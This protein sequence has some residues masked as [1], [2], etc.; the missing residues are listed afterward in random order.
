[1][2]SADVRALFLAHAYPRY[3][4]DPVG[5][6]V[7]NLAVALG[8]RGVEVVVSAPSAPGLAPFD[9]VN[10]VPVH[11][12]RYAPE[13]RETLAYTGTMGAQVKESLAGK[14]TMTS[15]LAAATRAAH[16]LLRASRFD[17][18]H[19]HWWFPAG[20]VAAGLRSADRVPFVTTLHGSD[21]RLADAFPFGHALFRRV[22]RRAGAMTAVSAWLA[23]GA[24][25]IAP[26]TTVT[27]APMPV[28]SGLFAPGEAREDD[29]LLFVGKL[30]EQKGLARLLR[31]MAAMRSRPR[32]AIVGAGRVDDAPL[33]RLANELG[34]DDRIEWLPLLTQAE[35]AHHYRRGAIHVVPAI[36]EGLGLTAVESLLS[37]TPV[38]GFDSGGLPDI[39]PDGVAG[40]L[41]PAGDEAALAHALDAV[42][43]DADA[44]HRMGRAG[45]AHAEQRFGPAAAAE[46]YLEIYERIAVR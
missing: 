17:V 13:R 16:R 35:L 42:L 26:F 34:L 46:R 14:L 2:P 33:R 8:A 4:A 10:G 25:S 38:V 11:R 30:T 7:G 27:V 23:R 21:L 44:R 32:L 40:R 12:F 43:L 3:D 22:A 19:A 24:E 36:D 41:V 45:R 29:L 28:L 39:V 18:V 15:Y 37:E 20:L 1:L 5:S 31:A 9:E 6:F